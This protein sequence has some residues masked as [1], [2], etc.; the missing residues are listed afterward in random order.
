MTTTRPSPETGAGNRG[1]SAWGAVAGSGS[2]PFVFIARRTVRHRNWP[3]LVH[4]ET[5]T[6]GLVLALNG[7]IAML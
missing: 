4:F 1:R 3:L 5:N 7:H 2:G 6:L